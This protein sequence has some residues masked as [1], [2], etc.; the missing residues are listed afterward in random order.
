MVDVF[1]KYDGFVEA[2]GFLQKFRDFRGHQPGSLI[3]HQLFVKILLVVDTVFDFIAVFVEHAFFRTP[4]G[5]VLIQIDANHFVGRQKSV[6]DP[7]AQG[8]GVDRLAK[9]I[10]VGDIFGFFRGCGQADLRRPAEVF[11]NLPPVGVFGGAAAMA[12]V[13]DNQVKKIR[14]KL[15]IDVLFFFGSR[16]GLIK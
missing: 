11:E 3:Q 9:I 5:Q 16:Y 12:L 15:F 8:I 6:V 4:A 14:G 10:D 2:V 7:L 1:T 13:H